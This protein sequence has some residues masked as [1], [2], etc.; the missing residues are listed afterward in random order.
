MRLQKTLH[1]ANGAFFSP[2]INA[3]A[4][5]NDPEINKMVSE[6]KAANLESTVVKLV[7]LN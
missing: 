7:S 2:V 5:Q 6:I 3:Q 1:V 4:Q